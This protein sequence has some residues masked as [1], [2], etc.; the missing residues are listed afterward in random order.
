M[1]SPK[2]EQKGLLVEIELPD[3]IVCSRKSDSSEKALEEESK[4]S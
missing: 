1:Q 4:K 2:K 3:M